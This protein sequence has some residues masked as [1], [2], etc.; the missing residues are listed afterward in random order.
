MPAE[1][2]PLESDLKQLTLRAAAALAARCA[3]RVQPIL[4]PRGDL[5]EASQKW[6]ALAEEFARG[7]DREPRVT[8]AI[9]FRAELSPRTP[10]QDPFPRDPRLDLP[11]A[12]GAAREAAKAVAGVSV[13]PSQGPAV[14][15]ASPPGAQ[16]LISH[17]AE[18]IEQ[19]ALVTAIT[20]EWI[21]IGGV[22]RRDY[23]TRYPRQAQETAWAA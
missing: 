23:E 17:A 8:S 20:L 19:A 1:P 9:A 22:F 3:R 12:M 7:V 11:H 2:H 14:A 6:I 18:A 10:V 15:P 5:L 4:A 21:P 13:I 16:D